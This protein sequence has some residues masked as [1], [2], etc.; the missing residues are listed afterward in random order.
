MNRMAAVSLFVG[1]LAQ[2]VAAPARCEAAEGPQGHSS[3]TMYM[4][5]NAPGTPRLE[6]LPL[7]ESVSEHGI[8]WTFEKPARVGQFVTGSWYVVGPVTIA[9][10][11]PAP[12]YGE[13]ARN[14]SVLNIPV[15]DRNA[16]G[17]DSRVHDG[18]YKASL[19]AKLPLTMK[20]GD[21]LIS[22]ISM[23][24]GAK[25]QEPSGGGTQS[26]SP[27]LSACVLTCLA[28]PAPADAFRPGYCDRT[29]T[30]RLARNLRR[31]LLPRLPY[32]KDTFAWPMMG[33]IWNGKKATT[34]EDWADRYARPWLEIC[35]FNFD[36]ALAYQPGYG[37]IEARMGSMVSLILATDLPAERKERLLLNYVQHGL[38]LYSIARAGYYGW[39][40]FGGHGSA[41]KWPIVLAGMMLGDEDMATP[42]KSCPNCLFG[43]D[44]QTMYGKGWTGATVVFGGHMYGSPLS[45]WQANPGNKEGDKDGGPYEH[46]APKDWVSW[47]HQSESYRRCC[48][49]N[50]WVGYALVAQLM[51]AEKYWAHDAFFDYV[52]RWMYEDQGP[53]LEELN[54]VCTER[55]WKVFKDGRGP[56]RR[57]SEAFV[58]EMWEKYRPMVEKPTDGWKKAR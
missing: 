54:K 25:P 16:S 57:A 1:I 18:R 53:I 21:A 17:F 52:D 8:T 34:A 47:N 5:E 46:K 56:G 42:N 29:Q 24:E 19:A 37:H 50:S 45:F 22:T 51:K 27:V 28:A 23:P 13:N 31:E 36:A 40:A 41:R 26:G 15:A 55:G 20:P 4:R 6:D 33:G 48:T 30:I 43:E 12:T 32:G 3:V 35:W 2:V 38:D 39:A 14:G 7:R 44:M 58:N 49:G 11:D 9:K 10:I